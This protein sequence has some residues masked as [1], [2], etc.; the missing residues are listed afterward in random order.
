MRLT[1]TTHLEMGISRQTEN[2]LPTDALANPLGN[3]VF[4]P[5][6]AETEALNGNRLSGCLFFDQNATEP[7]R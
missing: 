4:K 2:D 6:I 1:S 3:V 7:A 5:G